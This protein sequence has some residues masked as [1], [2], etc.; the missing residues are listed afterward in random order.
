[1]WLYSPAQVYEGVVDALWFSVNRTGGRRRTSTRD[2]ADEKKNDEERA[3]EG[4]GGNSGRKR[5]ERQFRG[6]FNR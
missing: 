6:R 3:V 5:R 4:D 1:M 2:R